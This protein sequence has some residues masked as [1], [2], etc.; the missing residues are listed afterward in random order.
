MVSGDNILE[1]KYFQ[2]RQLLFCILYEQNRKFHFSFSFIKGLRRSQASL[3]ID[4][5]RRLY[6]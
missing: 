4:K 3:N 1:K 2:S 5:S 6:S